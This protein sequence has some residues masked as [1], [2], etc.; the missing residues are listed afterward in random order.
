MPIFAQWPQNDSEPVA[1]R[2]RLK[3]LCYSAYGV[4]IGLAISLDLLPHLP[5][6]LIP[7]GQEHA[8]EPPFAFF[9]FQHARLADGRSAFQVA[10]NG[11][12][13]F[14]SGDVQAA[15][16]VLESRVH[17]YVA[18]STEAAVFV[19]AGVVR[20]DGR[21]VAI[22]GP[23]HSGK[24]TLVAALVSAGATYYSDEY[25]VIDLEGRVHAFPRQLRLRA[26]ILQQMVTTLPKLPPGTPLQPLPLGWVLNIRYN[27][28]GT[29]RPGALTPG[30]TLL[31]LLENTVAVRRQSESTIKIL[32]T[33]VGFAAGWNSERAGATKAAQ[34]ILQFLDRNRQVSAPQKAELAI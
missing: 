15:A 17:Q 30:Q 34:D 14:L 8:P 9:R 23:S 13:I 31:A 21:A 11:S 16:R 3:F 1:A 24:S 28:A 22:P 29:W 2:E 33:A 26:D 27:P 7:G 18:A 10:D 4:R 6:P 20:W 12:I 5:S 32:K 25:A 19:H